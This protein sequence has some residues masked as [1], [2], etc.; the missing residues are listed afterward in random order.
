VCTGMLDEIYLQPRTIH[1]DSGHEAECRQKR[2][3]PR[4]H[5]L[6]MAAFKVRNARSSNFFCFYF[7]IYND[8]LLHGAQC[9]RFA[10]N[11]LVHCFQFL[12]PGI[13]FFIVYR[14]SC[15][16][17]SSRLRAIVAHCAWRFCSWVTERSART[18]V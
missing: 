7:L 14:S 1:V 2:N 12:V 17:S 18:S 9:R 8:Y 13:R 4:S 11:Q 10:H 6:A 5:S 15:N 16:M 3:F